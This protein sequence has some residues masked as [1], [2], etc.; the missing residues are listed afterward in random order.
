MTVTER[1]ILTQKFPQA[2]PKVKAQQR[3]VSKIAPEIME[4]SWIPEEW[5]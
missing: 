3:T 4:V 1:P 2:N 5:R